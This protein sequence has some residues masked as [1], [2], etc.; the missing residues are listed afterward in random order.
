[1][2]LLDFGREAATNCVLTR[3]PFIQVTLT[4]IRTMV[5]SAL[6]ESVLPLDAALAGTTTPCTHPFGN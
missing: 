6:S 3:A 2:A 5:S 1:M 4:W